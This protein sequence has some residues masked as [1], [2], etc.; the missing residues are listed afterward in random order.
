LPYRDSISYDLE[1]IAKVLYSVTG[2]TS[3]RRFSI[4][5]CRVCIGRQSDKNSFNSNENYLKK[6]K[7]HSAVKQLITTQLYGL[8][9]VLSN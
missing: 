6:T 7:D 3:R 5:G 9:L 4:H 1:N 8:Q 2:F